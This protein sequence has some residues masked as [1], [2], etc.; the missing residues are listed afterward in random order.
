MFELENNDFERRCAHDLCDMYTAIKNV[1]PYDSNSLA[2][3][4]VHMGRSFRCDSRLDESTRLS[5]NGLLRSIVSVP[6][7]LEFCIVD[8]DMP[9]LFLRRASLLPTEREK[10]VI[11]NYGVVDQSLFDSSKQALIESLSQGPQKFRSISWPP[12]SLETLK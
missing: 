2:R 4:H 3:L 9:P 8:D 11:L 12:Q 7:D 1:R 5:R 10:R 6:N